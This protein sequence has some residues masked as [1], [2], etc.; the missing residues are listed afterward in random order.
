M[1]RIVSAML[2]VTKCISPCTT[3]IIRSCSS[4]VVRVITAPSPRKRSSRG[5]TVSFLQRT[6]VAMIVCLWSEETVGPNI[7]VEAGD[8]GW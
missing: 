4:G 6:G 8:L 5:F 1:R 7:G 2:S 3:A